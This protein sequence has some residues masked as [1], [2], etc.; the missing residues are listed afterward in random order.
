LLH[1]PSLIACSSSLLLQIYHNK[2][3]NNKD[4]Y[5]KHNA[6]SETYYQST[7]LGILLGF[8]LFSLGFNAKQQFKLSETRV[9]ESLIKC[10]FKVKAQTNFKNKRLFGGYS[11]KAP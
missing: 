8:T 2:D 10:F 3:K 1:F 5:C 11:L 6:K 4:C 7:K 9:C